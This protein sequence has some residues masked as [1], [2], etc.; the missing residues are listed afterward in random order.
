M[1]PQSNLTEAIHAGMA[2]RDTMGVSRLESCY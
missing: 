1:K 2:H